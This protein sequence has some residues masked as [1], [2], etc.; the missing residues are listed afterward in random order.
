MVASELI[1]ALQEAMREYGDFEVENDSKPVGA[2]TYG[3]REVDGK[4][5]DFL[6]LT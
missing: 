1:V 3:R 5:E 4:P 6:Y 2:I